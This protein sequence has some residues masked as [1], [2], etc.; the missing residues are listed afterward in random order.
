[1][2]FLSCFMLSTTWYKEPLF[3]LSGMWIVVNFL[4]SH[5]D[6]EV[7]LKCFLVINFEITSLML[8]E[9]VEWAN[10]NLSQLNLMMVIGFYASNSKE[11]G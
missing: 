3:L 1:M 2:K 9:L 4:V 8:C 10:L 5:S 7:N 6:A 11:Y